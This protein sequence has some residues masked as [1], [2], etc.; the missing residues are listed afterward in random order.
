MFLQAGTKN[1][2]ASSRQ[3]LGPHD[4]FLYVD[5]KTTSFVELCFKTFVF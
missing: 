1:I 2:L 5:A 3:L 4:M